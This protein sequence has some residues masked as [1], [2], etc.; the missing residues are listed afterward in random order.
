MLF[1]PTLFH[2]RKNVH[3][4]TLNEF[5]DPLVK[6][7]WE[8]EKGCFNLPVEDRIQGSVYTALYNKM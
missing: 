7:D 4:D 3:G 8:F 2:L 6:H 5:Y 1:Y